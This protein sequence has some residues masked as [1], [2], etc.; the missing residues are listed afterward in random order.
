METLA[1]SGLADAIREKARSG[2]PILGICLGMQ[3]LFEHSEEFGENI[4]LGI[5]EG[6]VGA[7][8]SGEMRVPNVGWRTLAPNP[9]NSFLAD[10]SP[11]TMVYFVHSF[12]AR[13]QD[14]SIVAAT[15]PFNGEE[16]AIAVASNEIMGFQ[17]HP[18]KRWPV[19]L[20]Y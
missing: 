3:L 7:L 17:F 18:E 1:T 14:V 15:I 12:V 16:A 2:A 20:Y 6:S 10:I 13:P 9:N 11:L 5:L 19:G 8:N 4:G